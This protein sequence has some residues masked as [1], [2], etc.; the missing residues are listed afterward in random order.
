MFSPVIPTQSET[1]RALQ[2]AFV[3]GNSRC[4]RSV[5]ASISLPACT[6]LTPDCKRPTTSRFRSP[7]FACDASSANGVQMSISLRFPISRSGSTTPI[8]SR[9]SP[10][11]SIGVPT[12]LGSAPNCRV[13]KPW[14]SRTTGAAAGVSSVAAK[15]RP[16][17]GVTPKTSNRLNEVCRA[18]SRAGS[19]TPVKV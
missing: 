3:A 4:K 5:I 15:D 8:I 9:S 17:T 18:E 12:T 7:R 14:L 16:R 2:P 1:T 19:E 6:R 11:S 13:Q 10:S